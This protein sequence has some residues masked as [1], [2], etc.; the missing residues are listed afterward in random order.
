MA[1]KF[2][3]PTMVLSV[4]ALSKNMGATKWGSP[5]IV[6]K[7]P[8]CCLIIFISLVCL[9]GSPN[10]QGRES[11]DEATILKIVDQVDSGQLQQ[12]IFELQSRGA[13]KTLNE[14]WETARWLMTMF[15]SLGV[16]SGIHLYEFKSR[17]WPNVIAHIGGEGPKQEPVL[18][19][20]H[21]DTTSGS[22][23]ADDNGSGIAAVLEIARVMSGMPE[24]ANVIIVIF[25]NEEIGTKGS[26]AFVHDV[27]FDMLTCK[28][29]I[30]LDVLAYNNR[31]NFFSFRAIES[32]IP[33]K[34]KLRALY[35]LQRNY[36]S[37]DTYGSDRIK[38]A[39]KKNNSGLVN[40]VA[41]G[42][43]KF[44]DLRVHKIISEDCG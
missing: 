25:S 19:L 7:K 4:N 2:F 15:R 17:L 3:R 38:V 27:D 43:L 22:P 16:R 23:G 33:I 24:P 12:T 29:V 32:G 9:G 34:Y 1:E 44:T 28:A 6:L 8:R 5:V 31:E 40:A 30:N 10:A 26:K 36:F 13:R 42:L 18:L 21:L 37:S 41:D 35:R 11:L 20:A 14:Q 39:G